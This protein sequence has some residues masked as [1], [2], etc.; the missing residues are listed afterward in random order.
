[1]DSQAINIQDYGL[2]FR[3]EL[4]TNIDVEQEYAEIRGWDSTVLSTHAVRNDYYVTT[5]RR[6][7]DNWHNLEHKHHVPEAEAMELINE[8]YRIEQERRRQRERDIIEGEAR[9]IMRPDKAR[10][11]EIAKVLGLP[12]EMLGVTSPRVINRK[13]TLGGLSNGTHD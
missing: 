9:I 10:V 13:E 11:L 7:A 6:S 2:T 12:P 4:V 1:M 8:V 3:G 5:I